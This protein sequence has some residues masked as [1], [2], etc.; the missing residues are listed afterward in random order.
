MQ[1]KILVIGQAPPAVKQGVPY[2]TTMLYDWL[3]EIGITKEQAQFLFEWEAVYDRFPGFTKSGA[4]AVPTEAM[5]DLYWR[6]TLGKK[7]LEC[8]KIWVVGNV[9]RDYLLKKHEKIVE[10]KTLL[11]TMHPSKRNM[12]AFKKVKGVMLDRIKNF[13]ND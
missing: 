1:S 13:I 3:S 9:A 6:N 4:H 5:M 10:K 8:N 11:F 12:D 7:V 2:D